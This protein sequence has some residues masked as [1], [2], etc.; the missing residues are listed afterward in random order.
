MHYYI[1]LG[2]GLTNIDILVIEE[3]LAINLSNFSIIIIENNF[4]HLFLVIS[5]TRDQELFWF[6][7]FKKKHLL[8]SWFI[9]QL[10]YI[11]NFTSHYYI[12]NNRKL[13]LYNLTSIA[14]FLVLIETKKKKLTA[15]IIRSRVSGIKI[16]NRNFSITFNNVYISINNKIG[17]KNFAFIIIFKIF[18]FLY[19]S[20]SAIYAGTCRAT[21]IYVIKLYK[22]YFL[23]NTTIK[24]LIDSIALEIETIRL[25]T[26]KTANLI[27]KNIKYLWFIAFSNF[28]LT[29]KLFYL[30]IKLISLFSY[31]QIEKYIYIQYI[32]LFY[33]KY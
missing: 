17:K 33:S 1:P 32:K 19:P 22:R 23:K 13:I 21:L 24:I 14:W 18:Y 5:G 9:I 16:N 11:K 26:W 31:I 20:I 29:Q 12:V 28:Y 10:S 7:M 15:F 27:N 25:L 30:Y 8:C 3:E 6:N 4:V 2:L